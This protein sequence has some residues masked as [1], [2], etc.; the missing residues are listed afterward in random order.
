MTSLLAEITMWTLIFCVAAAFI[1]GFVD[2]VA[3]GGGLIQLPVLLW[4]FPTAPLA[5]VLGTNKAVSVVGTSAAAITYR[6]KI[7]INSKVLLP[8]MATAFAGSVLGA[9]LATRV[10]RAWFEPIIL[11]ILIGVGLVTIFR[12]EFGKPQ[13]QV[14]SPSPVLA[15][16]L[17][18]GIGFYDGLIGPGTGMFLVFGLVALLKDSFL[19]ASALAKF[20]NVSTN[21]AALVIFIPGGY[22]MWLVAALMAPAN[23]LGGFIGARTAL[24]RGS[25]FVRI[26][27][28]VMLGV[29]ITRLVATIS[30]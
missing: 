14:R 29:L 24:T 10:E 4:S 3:G 19:S 8:M 15:P 18:L 25:V 16:L 22:V 11:T 6:K 2:A 26:I 9:I 12:P 7:A 20:V 30:F 5:S 17:G 21:L 28:L 13:L 27:F 23:L 1:A